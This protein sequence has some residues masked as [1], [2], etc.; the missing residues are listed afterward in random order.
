MNESVIKWATQ[1]YYSIAIFRVIWWTKC[2]RHNESLKWWWRLSSTCCSVQ[3]LCS[4]YHCDWLTELARHFHLS[5]SY[6]IKPSFVFQLL[7]SEVV[8]STVDFSLTATYI[9]N[10]FFYQNFFSN[11]QLFLFLYFGNIYYKML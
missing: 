7:H 2:W 6:T 1:Y 11:Y 5:L 9:Y 8:L 4:P 3:L 10:F